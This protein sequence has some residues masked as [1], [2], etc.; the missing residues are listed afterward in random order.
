VTRLRVAVVG[1]GDISAV[2]LDAILAAPDGGVEPV[3]VCD[4]DATRRD[5]AADRAG[6]PA[7]AD[8]TTLLDTVAPD[9][10]HLCTPHH[11][12]A[13]LAAECLARGVSV[14]V[15][16]PI[17]HAL[18]DGERL[19]IAAEDSDAVFGVCF[20][21]RYNDTARHLKDLLDQGELG[22]VLGARASVTWFRDTAYYTRRDWR[23]RWATAGGGVLMNQ[24]IH[25]LDLLQWFLGPV[26]DVRGTA[27][28]LAL[29]GVIE[30]EDTAALRMRHGDSVTSIVHA[31][32]GD[33]ENA[34]AGIELVTE[35]ARVRLDTDLTV[36]HD[37]GRVEVVHPA[38]VASG[39]KAYW[40]ASHG[41]LIDDFH[42]HVRAGKPFWIDAAA[43]LETLRVIQAVYDQSPGLSR[44]EQAPITPRDS[45][46]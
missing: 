42:R 15:E 38:A 26:T 28:T 37:D 33:V 24:A 22:R 29:P 9:V 25:T 45:A 32:N 3:G 27:A 2:H 36:T 30:V 16:K 12:H 44:Q 21:N 41:L 34:P 20:Q 46:R 10:V 43:G 13:D 39:E 4:V 1:C 14:L 5:A 17:A 31:T 23:G 6:C 35:R 40:G 11:R 19:A 18:D 8:L 7:F